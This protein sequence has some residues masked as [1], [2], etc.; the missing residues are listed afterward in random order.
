MDELLLRWG[1]YARFP[2][3]S[4]TRSFCL[5]VSGAVAPSA[6]CT[7]A[8]HLPQSIYPD[9]MAPPE[10]TGAARLSALGVETD[11]DDDVVAR[12]VRDLHVFD[13]LDEIAR[14]AA[15]RKLHGDVVLLGEERRLVAL[16]DEA[17]R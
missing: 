15:A 8:G 13:D 11:P 17:E 5:S 3:F 12:H 16:D 1:C 6:P 14:L 10:S 9:G 4:A 2:E 7:M